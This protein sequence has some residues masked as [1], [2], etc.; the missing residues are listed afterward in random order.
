NQIEIWEMNNALTQFLIA[1]VKENNKLKRKIKKL[2]TYCNDII[3][4]YKHLIKRNYVSNMQFKNL[5]TLKK[6]FYKY[7]VV[8]K[9]QTLDI[10]GKERKNIETAIE[11]IDKDKNFF[12]KTFTKIFDSLEEEMKTRNIIAALRRFF[13]FRVKRS[14]NKAYSNKKNSFNI[15]MRNESDYYSLPVNLSVKANNKN[16]KFANRNIKGKK[17]LVLPNKYSGDT[18]ETITFKIKKEDIKNLIIKINLDI[19]V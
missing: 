19:G 8:Y 12:K 9:E 15:I 6:R 10:T 14:T 5:I 4:T 17:I 18:E 16:V 2:E 3:S 13:S 11:N 7:Y 1:S